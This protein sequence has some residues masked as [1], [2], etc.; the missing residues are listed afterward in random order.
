MDLVAFE[1]MSLNGV[2]S[3]QIMPKTIWRVEKHLKIGKHKHHYKFYNN[4]KGISN[5]NNEKRFEI[6]V[7]ETRCNVT[8]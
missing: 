7:F 8:S 4:G 5:L 3:N 2:G 6:N 1:I